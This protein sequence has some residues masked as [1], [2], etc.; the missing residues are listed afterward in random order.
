M[1]RVAPRAYTSQRASTFLALAGCSGAMKCGVPRPRP[2]E[3]RAASLSQ[4]LAMPEAAHDMRM[5]EPAGSLEFALEALDQDL[6]GSGLLVQHFDRDDIPRL[7]VDPLV[8]RPHSALAEFFDEVV[9][10]DLFQDYFFGRHGM[11][12]V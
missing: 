10:T 7:A 9:V 12:L 2:L 6:V 4:T 11:D 3:G 5:M 1:Y 8:H